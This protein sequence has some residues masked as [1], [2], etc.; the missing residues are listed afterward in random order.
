MFPLQLYYE[1]EGYSMEDYTVMQLGGSVWFQGRDQTINAYWNRKHH[2]AHSKIS[3]WPKVL[4]STRTAAGSWERTAFWWPSEQCVNSG[5]NL[6]AVRQPLEAEIF[7]MWD[8]AFSSYK[9]GLLSRL[10]SWAALG[11]QSLPVARTSPRVW[12]EEQTESFSR[13][14]TGC[15]QT[16]TPVFASLHTN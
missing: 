9:T 5:T 14:A 15:S 16:S 3:A 13:G 1:Q 11:L 12:W 2:L 10:P 4:I 8:V 7:L 6:K